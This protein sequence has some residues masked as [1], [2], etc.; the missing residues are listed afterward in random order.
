MDT[1]FPVSLSP[2]FLKV[3]RVRGQACPRVCAPNLPRSVTPSTSGRWATRAARSAL[4]VVP[5]AGTAPAPPPPR[6][7]RPAPGPPRSA[8]LAPP[9][10]RV[11][12]SLGS[13]RGSRASCCSPSCLHGDSASQA[14]G[15]EPS[16][17]AERGWPS[18][19]GLRGNSLAGRPE[20]WASGTP[21]LSKH[22]QRS[23]V[24]EFCI[25]EIPSN[26]LDKTEVVKAPKSRQNGRLLLCD[27]KEKLMSGSNKEKPQKSSFGRR[28]RLSSKLCT[29][30]TQIPGGATVFSARKETSS[31]K[32]EDKVSLKSSENRPSSRSIE[33]NRQF[34]LWSSSFLKE[35]SGEVNKDLVL[36][37]QEKNSEY[38]LEDI[39]E[40]LSDSTDGDGE[41]DSNNEDDEGPAKKETR[42]PLELMAEFLRAEMGRDYQLAKKL[43]QMILIYEPEN[44]VAKEFFSLIEEILL[45][46]KAQEE[47]EEEESDED[48]SSESEVDSSEDGSEDSSDECEDGS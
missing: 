16:S 29:S 35:S 23:L 37:K 21:R 25:P 40:N 11:V 38:C 24:P 44:P 43:C 2:A 20:G 39:E 17:S 46:E 47:E 14:R 4:H 31:K 5:A 13:S 33:T 8:P 28:P 12:Q 7:L 10:R 34:D 15:S 3:T 36:A 19:S 30:P 48:S 41:E 26:Y 42:A 32:I 9:L 6:A 18:W 1:D 27:P 22:P 45:K